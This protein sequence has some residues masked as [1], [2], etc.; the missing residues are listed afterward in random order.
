LANQA[1]RNKKKRA[2]QKTANIPFSIFWLHGP[3]VLHITLNKTSFIHQQHKETHRSSQ[4]S[5]VHDVSA[6]RQCN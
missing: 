2:A 1:D 3:E 5:R 6:K 4:R